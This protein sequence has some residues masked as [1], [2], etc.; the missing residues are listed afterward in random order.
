MRLDAGKKIKVRGRGKLIKG[1]GNIYTPVF[2]C[3]YFL[4]FHPILVLS[5][6][7]SYLSGVIFFKCD[8]RVPCAHAIWH[9]F[10]FMGAS[11]HYYAVC[12]H[13]L[14]P[15]ANSAIWILST[16]TGTWFGSPACVATDITAHQFFRFSSILAPIYQVFTNRHEIYFFILDMIYLLY[17]NVPHFKLIYYLF[18][19]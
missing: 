19:S 2:K 4:F 16:C 18:C 3:S 5:I 8:G 9:L 1:H 17:L 10:V 14:L 7:H 6:F 12:Q 13:L 15:M 11:I